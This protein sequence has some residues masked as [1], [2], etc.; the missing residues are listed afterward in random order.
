VKEMPA[1]RP[2]VINGKTIPSIKEAFI[3]GATVVEA[4]LFAGI[5]KTALYDYLK[6]HPEFKEECEAL[7]NQTTL[8]AKANI[9]KSIEN[10]NI[11]DSKWHLEK[12]QE[13]YNPKQKREVSGM[14]T[15]RTL[16]GVLKDG[17]EGDTID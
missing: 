7:A 10:G 3:L 11:T 13:D 6:E 15:H 12:T 17:D 2:E 16:L 5:S 4:A 14:V 8:K 9:K 1:G